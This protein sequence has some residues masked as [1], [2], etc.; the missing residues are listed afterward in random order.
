MES[1][2]TLLI[3]IPRVLSFDSRAYHEKRPVDVGDFS[4][5][6]CAATVEAVVASSWFAAR[7]GGVRDIVREIAQ[8]SLAMSREESIKP[9]TLEQTKV[10]C[11]IEKGSVVI[12]RKIPRLITLQKQNLH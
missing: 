3:R 11:L 1:Q 10:E 6:E 7:V 12:G 4:W 9:S 2:T 5:M 8:R